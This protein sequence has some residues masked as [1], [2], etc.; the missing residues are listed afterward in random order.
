MTPEPKIDLQLLLVVAAAATARALIS[1]GVP[2]RQRAAAAVASILFAYL[3]TPA[4]IELIGVYAGGDVSEAVSGAVGASIAIA[5]EPIIRHI[6]ELARRPSA[7][8]GLARSVI[9]LMK[10]ITGRAGK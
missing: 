6:Y 4:A 5:A 10:I 3:M 9:E 8:L 1:G 7:I 2:A